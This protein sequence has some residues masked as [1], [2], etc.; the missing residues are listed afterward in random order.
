MDT[1]EI[2]TMTIPMNEKIDNLQDDATTGN[3]QPEN[4]HDSKAQPFIRIENL[5]KQFDGVAVVDSVN[6]DIYRGEL[7]A[8]LGS[9][10]CGKTTLLRML[11]GFETPSTGRVVIDGIDITGLPP[12]QRPVNM[13]VQSYAVFP[14]MTVE[15][16]VAYG[17]KKEGV[18]KTRIGEQVAQILSLVQLSGYEKRKPHQL[19]GGQLQR[20]ALARALVK[21]PKVLLLDEPLAALDK[22]LRERTQ[23]ELMNIQDELGITFVVVTHDQEEAMNLATRI[24]VMDDGRFVQTGT[25]THVYEYPTN[26]F[27]ADF[28]GTTNMFEGTVSQIANEHLLIDTGDFGV[29]KASPTPGV[30]EGNQVWLAVRPEKITISK[31]SITSETTTCIKG[32]VTDLGYYGNRTIYRVTTETSAVIEISAQNQFRASEPILDSEDEVF[33]SWDLANSIVLKE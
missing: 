33:V 12:Y 16:N 8:I 11:A 4:R 10:G 31:E 9:S 15:K 29:I 27:V 22:K 23:F 25:P 18:D 13:M 28:V 20:V 14:H 5:S 32:V 21:K 30:N 19:S 1:R 2:R 17:L 6:L 26:R 3:A 24:A 7:F